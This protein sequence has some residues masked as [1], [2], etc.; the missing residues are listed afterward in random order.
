MGKS[1]SI[2]TSKIEQFFKKISDWLKHFFET[3]D[4][5]ETIAVGAIA[6]GFVFFIIGIIII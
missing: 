1:I 5:E 2:D 4:K 3:I 6:L